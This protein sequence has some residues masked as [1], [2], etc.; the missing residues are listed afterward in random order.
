M[1]ANSLRNR[2]WGSSAF[3]QFTI[4][5]NQLYYITSS[6]DQRLAQ[7]QLTLPRMNSPPAHN[8]LIGV[9]LQ[10]EGKE[11]WQVGG[12]DSPNEPALKNAYFLGP[13]LSFEGDL[14]VLV[15]INLETRL[16]VLDSRTGKQQWAQQLTLS[17]L[18][19]I[20]SDH[21]RQSQALSPSI[22]DAVVVCRLATV[23]LSPSTCLRAV[24]FGVSSIRAFHRN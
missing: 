23:P 20:R 14:Y 18:M 7:P 24:C 22:A 10:G 15:E 3:G 9:S 5:S 11:M 16:V 4:D 19:P 17:P 13:P 1:L 6:E 21:L 8:M 12:A 2:I